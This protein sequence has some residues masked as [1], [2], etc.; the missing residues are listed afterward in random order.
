VADRKVDYLLVGG[1][2]ASAQCAAELRRRGADGSILLV[3]REPDPPYD[4]PPLSKEYLRGEHGRERAYVHE[5]DWYAENDVELLTAKSVMSLDVEART[6]KL[7][8]KQE[9]GFDK[10][11]IATG[12]MVNI[13]RVDGAQ[14]DGI[15][16]LRA[17]GNSDAI[18][19]DL[20]GVEHVVLIGGSYIG[21]EVAA[22]LVQLGKRCTIVMLE[23]VLLSRVFGDEAGRY[24]HDLLES[25][26]VEIV[27][28]EELAAFVGA[29]RVSGVRTKDGREIGA[30]AV[31]VGAGVKPDVV[32]AQR[33]G[34]EVD[35]G[36]LVDAGLETSVGGIF[37]A[38]DCARY[39][40][41]RFGGS[42]RI[43]HWDV[44]FQQGRHAARGMIGE[45]SP[46][47]VIPYFFSDLADWASLEY[48]GHATQWDRVIF[49]GDREAGEFSAWYLDQGVVEAAL[50]VGRS[51]D[52]QEARRLIESCEKLENPDA[53]ADAD[54]DLSAIGV[55][56]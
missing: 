15:H 54:S 16:Y 2:L 11:L 43:E 55:C 10:A 34:L 14:L 5:T 32:L 52:L 49:R 18:R 44:A 22:S 45:K 39:E 29:D 33:A 48:V 21:A 7:Q 31:V 27:G 35:D 25:K 46:Y 40:S 20:S 26:G 12:A 50:S 36:V 47:E 9:V 53:L 38:G 8:G 23:E 42:L 24:F 19:E 51:E 30:E 56:R 13:L 3:G 6:A 37:A 28:G 17:F 4:R 41:E 1:G